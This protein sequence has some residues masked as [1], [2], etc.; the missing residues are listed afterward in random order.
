MN[1]KNEMKILIKENINKEECD[2]MCDNEAF[3]CD[4][5]SNF[6]EC[7]IMAK[8]RCNDDLNNIFAESINYGG[9]DNAE[10]FW[11]QIFD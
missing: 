2:Y 1:E 7:Y 3:N 4:E 6:E 11:E 9:Y 8:V 5:C 10:D